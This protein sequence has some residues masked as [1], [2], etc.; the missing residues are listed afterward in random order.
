MTKTSAISELKQ[1]FGINEIYAKMVFSVVD[2][3]NLIN[4]A[5]R[6][7]ANKPSSQKSAP[8]SPK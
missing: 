5:Y 7:I 4:D 8:K 3:K 2:K 1:T 6:I